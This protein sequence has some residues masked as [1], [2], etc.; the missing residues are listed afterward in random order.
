META[1]VDIRKLQL[2]NDR[3]CQTIDALNQ[4]RLSVH[5]LTGLSHTGYNPGI[6]GTVPGMGFGQVF[7]QTGQVPGVNTLGMGYGFNPITQIPFVPGLAHT[8]Y[9]PTNSP[10]MAANTTANTPF[11]YQNPLA[12]QSAL[13][14]QNPLAAQTGLG[15]QGPFGLQSVSAQS[16]W[17]N[18]FVG[19][20][21]TGVDVNDLS[22]LNAIN[23]INAINGG[24]SSIDPYSAYTVARLNQVFPFA[25]Y[26]YSPVV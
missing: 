25:Q 24:I 9:N 13:G 12:Y 14:I 26:P 2:L 6:P 17:M 15:I 7:G 3:I 20:S 5:G 11:A 4:V 18:P 1:K 22:R 10:W 8:G 23:A 16:P 21:H 19:L